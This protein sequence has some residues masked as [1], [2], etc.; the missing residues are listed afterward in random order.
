MM[1][2]PQLRRQQ[3][4]SVGS[5]VLQRR[6]WLEQ[7]VCPQGNRSWT[8]AYVSVVVAVIVGVL[9]GLNVVVEGKC[10]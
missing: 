7:S 4:C 2:R 3:D 8:T 9:V 5:A 6:P 10:E 1:P